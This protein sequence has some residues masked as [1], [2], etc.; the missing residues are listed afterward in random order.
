[1]K[2]TDLNGTK[3]KKVQAKHFLLMMKM[4]FFLL[5]TSTLFSVT[6]AAEQQK[7]K[8]SGIISDVSGEPLVGASIVEKG[9][10][11]GTLTNM[12]GMFSL[13]VEENAVI[14]VS[15]IGFLSQ[16]INTAGK[17]S[18]NITLIEDTRSL[19]E[20]VVVGYGTQ[21]K[22]NLTGAVDQVDRKSVV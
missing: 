8:L 7:K 13:Q 3:I 5:I 18:V 14:Q 12:N 1:M 9:T 11:N 16:E 20:V 6:H 2:K 10:T 17:T 22:A 4:L 19:E 15:Y 21:K